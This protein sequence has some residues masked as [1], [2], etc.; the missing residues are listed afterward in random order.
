MSRMRRSSPKVALKI[1]KVL[2]DAIL[3]AHNLAFDLNFIR[4]EFDRCGLHWP[5]TRAEVDT[6][7][8]LA[9]SAP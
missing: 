2:E 7:P 5:A 8:A 6:L 1:R 3:V 4:S 9:A